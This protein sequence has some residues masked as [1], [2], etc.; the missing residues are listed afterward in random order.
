M[1]NKQSKNMHLLCFDPIFYPL[2]NGHM[3]MVHYGD[4]EELIKMESGVIYNEDGTATLS[5]FNPKA[6]KVEIRYRKHNYK[7]AKPEFR[8]DPDFYSKDYVFEPLTKDENGFWHGTI[9]P[10]PG[11]HSIYYYVDG[12]KTIDTKGPYGFDSDDIRNFVDIPDDPDTEIHDVPHGSI[13]REIY[14]SSITGRY[15]A[16]WVYTPASY[17]QS[18]K[19]Y[20]V[21]YIQH[22]GGQDEV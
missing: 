13:T 12:V 10:G 8:K 17:G 20:P 4:G 18:D 22:G 1:S 16:C 9:N 19:K 5:Y 11:F 7:F 21:L 3:K 15:R 14:K 2:E 6:K